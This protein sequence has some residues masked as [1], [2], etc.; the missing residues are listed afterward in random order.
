M[1]ACV[2]VSVSRCVVMPPKPLSFQLHM[3]R[4]HA[5]CC[6]S[7]SARIRT[8]HASLRGTDVGAILQSGHCRLSYAGVAE[9]ACLHCQPGRQ[10]EPAGCRAGRVYGIVA[11]WCHLPL[12][13]HF[14]AHGTTA[15]GGVA[16]TVCRG[17]SAPAAS[18]RT[19]DVGGFRGLLH[20]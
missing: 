9:A 20:G 19:L 14:G 5:T 6:A 8:P 1:F 7:I 3:Q 13:G 17:L 11:S 10:S 2:C 15:G 16:P 12:D 18:S 4:V